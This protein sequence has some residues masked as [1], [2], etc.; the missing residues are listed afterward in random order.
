MPITTLPP[1]PQRNDPTTFADKGDAL[2]GQLDLF[3]TEANELESNVNAA[4]TA[5]AISAAN[6]LSSESNAYTSASNAAASALS[7]LANAGA[8]VW[9]TSTLYNAGVVK[10][11]PTNFLVYR[12]NTTTTDSVDPYI[13][14]KWTLVVP[15]SA[16]ASIYAALNFG[17]L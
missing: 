5:A 4:E 6:A 11:S 16:A 14:P 15:P 13:N 2:L 12:C 10:Y 7:A 9:I 17:G 8:T 1:A 3:V